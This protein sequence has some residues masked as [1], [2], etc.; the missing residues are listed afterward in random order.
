MGEKGIDK[1]CA[2]MHNLVMD[3]QTF[4]DEVGVEDTDV[5]DAVGKDRSTISRIRRKRFRPDAETLLLL[6]AWADEIAKRKR[7]RVRER[8]TWDYL[9]SDDDAAA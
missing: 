1:S 3:L 6:N 4:M 9:L 2:P 5:A 8:L 7:L